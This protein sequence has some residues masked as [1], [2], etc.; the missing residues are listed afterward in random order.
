MVKKYFVFQ[1]FQTVFLMHV[2]MVYVWMESNP[3][4]AAVTVDLKGST[5]KQVSY[6][7]TV[8]LF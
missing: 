3:I 8:Y 4:H 5:V 6:T 7:F 1:I 2:N